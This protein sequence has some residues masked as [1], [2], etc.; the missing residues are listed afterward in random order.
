MQR[1]SIVVLNLSLSLLALLTACS[2]VDR[3]KPVRAAASSYA[4]AY[5]VTV[6]LSRAEIAHRL[7]NEFADWRGTRHR[8]GGN[9]ARGF[10][11][12][13]FSLH[14][15]AA[16]L[17][18]NLPRTTA[19]QA[20]LGRFI[21]RSHLKPGDLVFFRPPTYPRHVGVYVGN[22]E[23]VHASSS[24]GV[25]LS[26]LDSTYWRRHYWMSRRIVVSANEA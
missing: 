17:G 2:T 23:F 15:F 18:V 7:K 4:S 12:S 20:A 3:S 5:P 9:G 6:N 26:R 13:G 22:G 1:I 25:T 11:C 21:D 14:L 19:R 8:M 16:T 24:K 10:D